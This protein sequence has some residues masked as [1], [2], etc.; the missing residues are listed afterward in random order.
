MYLCG[1]SVSPVSLQVER[2]AVEV[3]PE[4]EVERVD[5]RALGSSVEGMHS[6]VSRS[7]NLE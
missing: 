7:E 5:S 1:V 2:C 4:E 3:E 6:H